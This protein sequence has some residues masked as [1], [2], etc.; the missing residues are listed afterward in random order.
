MSPE[1][2]RLK[3]QA[4]LYPLS[5]AEIHLS[6]DL[7]GTT[8]AWYSKL[9]IV[10]SIAS[11]RSTK[12]HRM[13][14]MG[15]GGC[16]SRCGGCC[17][18]GFR[19]K[20]I[21]P[22]RAGR[23]CRLP[24]HSLYGHVTL[25]SALAGAGIAEGS[26]DGEGADGEGRAVLLLF[27]IGPVQDFIAAARKTADLWA[28]SY[29]ISYLV[30]QGIRVICETCGPDAVLF[31]DLYG[32]P[33]ADLWLR[34]EQGL[35]EVPEPSNLNAATFPNRFFAVVPAGNAEKLAEQAK[36][37]VQDA[38]A[39]IGRYACERLHP[40][41]KG[42]NAVHA[43]GEMTFTFALVVRLQQTGMRCVASDRAAEH[44]PARRQ[45]EGDLS[46]RSIPGV[47]AAEDRAP[48]KTPPEHIIEADGTTLTGGLRAIRCRFTLRCTSKVRLGRFPGF[49]L[50]G[51]LK[52]RLRPLACV[53]GMSACDGCVLRAGRCAYGHPFETVHE[54]TPGAPTGFED[55][56]RPFV[57]HFP[58][59]V[60]SSFAAGEELRFEVV[61][62]GRAASFL[63]HL[64][65]AVRALEEAG[66]GA[67][68]PRGV[69]PGA[70][71]LASAG[72]A[73][74]AAGAA[75]RRHTGAS[76]RPAGASLRDPA[77]HPARRAAGRPGRLRLAPP[78]ARGRPTPHQ[79]A[80]GV[81]RRIRLLARFH[82]TPAPEAVLGD[83]GRRSGGIG[84]RDDPFR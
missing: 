15:Y 2:L 13:T 68:G 75:H 1:L 7:S 71:R 21:I 35:H 5:G 3:I 37:T 14:R 61:L 69:A 22:A 40:H 11:N 72:P 83:L 74:A 17:R 8:R 84:C 18:Y 9:W 33:L 79:V 80:R 64:V 56:P 67:G 82:G 44:H 55:A 26:R 41:E 10:P 77:T 78:R 59:A 46:L 27:T 32:Q 50:Y 23:Y 36:R 53:T 31:P 25:A 62:L 54:P 29:L 81:A 70:G 49:T 76:R 20:A 16:T 19:R 4:L 24:D 28:G 38:F 52:S 48:M 60:R 34:R 39:E 63:P 12:L 47:P 65:Y 43:M 57:L 66:L 58:D 45:P 42:T 51:A 73:A 6:D 30:W